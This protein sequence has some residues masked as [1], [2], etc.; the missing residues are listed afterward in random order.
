MLACFFS[1]SAC[2]QAE[3]V[4]EPIDPMISMA[5]EEGAKQ[6]INAF[7]AMTEEDIEAG[8]AEAEKA[9]ESVMVAAL[10]SW[11]NSK[12]D[13][14]DFVSVD[15]IAVERID[16]GYTVTLQTTFTQ[17]KMEF[18]VSATEDLAEVTEIVIAPEYT[19]PAAAPAPAPAPV[20]AAPAVTVSVAD[21]TELVAVITAAIAASEDVPP[22]G[23]VVRSIRHKA[24]N[25][26]KNA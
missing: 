17:R 24:S 10:T 18:S 26:W 3:T 8:I 25:N 16:E 14:G 19:A 7:E 4:E 22:E 23:L 9:K 21:N 2:G 15:S 13:L 12:A 6:Y 1:L 20:P 11:K 5:L